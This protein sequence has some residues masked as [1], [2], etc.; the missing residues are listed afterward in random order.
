MKAS[1]VIGVI[2]IVILA[3]VLMG[4][5]F[6]YNNI[7]TGAAVSDTQKEA[8]SQWEQR[9]Q[10]K[11]QTIT[12]LKA[13]NTKLKD[14][15]KQLKAEVE[16]IQKE[17]DTPSVDIT[18]PPRVVP[19]DPVLDVDLGQVREDLTF[20]RQ[21]KAE[22]AYITESRD[23][24]AKRLLDEKELSILDAN[25]KFDSKSESYRIIDVCRIDNFHLLTKTKTQA[26]E[27]GTIWKFES[28]GLGNLAQFPVSL[29]QAKV[30]EKTLT[31]RN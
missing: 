6:W 28:S 13:E 29:T 14:S 2:A 3:L 9:L 27:D 25:A 15:L 12:D 10:E 17:E 5:L 4:M 18:T 19:T 7:I 16:E 21:K 26:F 8:L 1:N 20:T 11:E 24:K 31:C 22:E 23:E 30:Y